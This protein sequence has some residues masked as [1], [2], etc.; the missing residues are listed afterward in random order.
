MTRNQETTKVQTI[1]FYIVVCLSSIVAVLLIVGSI[2]WGVLKGE[3]SNA[4]IIGVILAFS[5][6]VQGLKWFVGYPY[7][8]E[9]E[10]EV[11]KKKGQS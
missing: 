5:F 8:L 4:V 7:K 3:W 6:F 9:S 10:E 1:I 11:R 2:L